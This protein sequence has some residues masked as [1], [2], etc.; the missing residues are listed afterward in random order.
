M[1][2]QTA[3]SSLSARREARTARRGVGRAGEGGRGAAGS[4]SGRPHDA[5]RGQCPARRRREPASLPVPWPPPR[6][7]SARPDPLPPRPLPGLLRPLL[8]PPPALLPRGARAAPRAPG[9]P[10]GPHRQPGPA[11]P[12]EEAGLP[13]RAEPPSPAP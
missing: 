11:A 9:G 1:R 3:T 6:V 4:E 7:P 10:G 12:C 5:R 13:P 2:E 8:L